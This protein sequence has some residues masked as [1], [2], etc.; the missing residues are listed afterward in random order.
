MLPKCNTVRSQ[1]QDYMQC[2]FT[3]MHDLHKRT[4]ITLPLCFSSLHH[5][6]QWELPSVVTDLMLMGRLY[7]LA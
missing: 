3:N 1:L 2:S 7:L 4:W 5:T 6:S